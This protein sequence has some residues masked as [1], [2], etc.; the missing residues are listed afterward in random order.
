MKRPVSQLLAVTRS[1]ECRIVRISWPA[2]GTNAELIYKE[3]TAKVQHRK[4]FTSSSDIQDH[5]G[6]QL[7]E[8]VTPALKLVP[9]RAEPQPK[10][11]IERK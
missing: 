2:A 9:L 6:V 10:S 5:D 1:V 3:C 11:S 8:H 4:C 7:A